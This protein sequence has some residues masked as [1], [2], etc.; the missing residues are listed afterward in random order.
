[1]IIKTNRRYTMEEGDILSVSSH[2]EDGTVS[3][4]PDSF[5]CDE[6]IV[7]VV[8]PSQ[9]KALQETV[10]FITEWMKVDKALRNNKELGGK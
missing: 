2:S 6:A 5:K 8:G 10:A 4:I 9:L 7:L 3:L 1:M